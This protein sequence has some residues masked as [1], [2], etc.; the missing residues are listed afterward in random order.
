VDAGACVIRDAGTGAGLAGA[1]NNTAA[2]G[3]RNAVVSAACIRLGR[4]WDAGS[5][6]VCDANTGTGSH[7]AVGAN[8]SANASNGNRGA[9]NIRALTRAGDACAAT[10]Q[11]RAGSW[12]SLW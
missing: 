6:D 10:R 12:R 5:R 9:A 11:R 8:A 2:V 4:T 1:A 7:A 3:A